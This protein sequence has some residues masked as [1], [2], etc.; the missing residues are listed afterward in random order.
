MGIIQDANGRDHFSFTL[1]VPLYLYVLIGLG[2]LTPEQSNLL[3]FCS[4]SIL[5]NLVGNNPQ[6][7]SEQGHYFTSTSLL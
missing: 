6:L 3:L 7:V 1:A 4:D 5:P 2:P